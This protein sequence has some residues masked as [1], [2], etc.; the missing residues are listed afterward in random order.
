M[1][2]DEETQSKETTYPLLTGR[3]NIKIQTIIKKKRK[4]KV[5]GMS[6]QD[7]NPRNISKG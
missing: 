2:R 4:K 6:F 3:L 7:L 5:G 1:G